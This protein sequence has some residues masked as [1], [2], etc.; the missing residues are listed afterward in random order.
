MKMEQD[1]FYYVTKTL[2]LMLQG[3]LQGGRDGIV[4]V[5]SII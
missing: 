5:A 2:Y 4:V 3:V 1:N